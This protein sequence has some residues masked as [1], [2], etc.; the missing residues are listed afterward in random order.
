MN[1]TDYICRDK[2]VNGVNF[3]AKIISPRGKNNARTMEKLR[4]I[5]YIVVHNTGNSAATAGD[6][7][8]A[9][10]MQNVE[11]ADKDYVSWHITVD[12]DSAT[13]HL[14]F[15]EVGYHAGDGNGSGNHEGIGIEIAENK[16]YP[17]CEQNGIKII[18]AL[19]H[20][21]NIPIDRVLP[22]RYFSPVKKLCP[23]RILRQQGTWQA[24]WKAFQTRITAEYNAIY[25]A[26]K[27]EFTGLSIVGKSEATAEQMRAFLRSK[28]PTAAD[29]ARLY[30]QEAA[31]EGIRAD[32]AFAQSCLETN[33][34]KF[35]GAIKITQNNFAGI[36][37]GASFASP[38]RGIRAQIQHL[39]AYANKEPLSG[40]CVDPRFS[41]VQ[42]GVAP[43]V[44]WLAAPKN[45]S[46]KGWSTDPNYGEKI[47][48]ILAAMLSFAPTKSLVIGCKV[49]IR[50]G[51][52]FGGLS[53][54][55][56]KKVPIAQMD[57]KKH[58]V[59]GIATHYGVREARLSEINSWVAV[60]SLIVL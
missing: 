41:L 11:N 32:I 4:G 10:Y 57:G 42:R 17:A 8:H 53:T 20:D 28:N 24:D 59:C 31:K 50:P 19:M 33:F 3:A 22:H 48:A 44:E 1:L 14:P 2:A 38:E 55:R 60:D 35:G 54:A 40:E 21:F 43:F 5:K 56:G 52:V 7:S 16:N 45:P 36:S 9:S 34:F 12:S 29:Y 39:K 26:G 30:I 15:N 25:G 13:Q 51:A 23:S 49:A 46:G 47:K 27:D 6:E 18:C 37:G 58:T